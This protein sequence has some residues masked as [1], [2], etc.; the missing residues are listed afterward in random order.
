M[1]VSGFDVKKSFNREDKKIVTAILAGSTA[2]PFFVGW[3]ITS[4]YDCSK[5][6]GKADNKLAFQIVFAIAVAVT[7]IP[8]I[9]KIFLDLDLTKSRF[10][11]IVLGTAIIHD[12]VLY[13][14]LSIATGMVGAKNQSPFSLCVTV[15]MT[16]IFFAGALA[17]L[18]KFLQKV[19]NLRANL[20]FKSSATGYSLFICFLFAAV[21][22]LFNI[23]IVFGAFIAG[24]I[25][26]IMPERRFADS[27]SIIKEFSLA[28]FVP[29]YFAILGLKLDLIHKF[30]PRSF[31]WFLIFSSAVQFT[32]TILGAKAVKMSWLS[33]VNFAMVM[34]ARGGP[35]IVLASIAFDLGIISESF[36]TT[37]VLAAIL[38]SLLAGSWLRLVL[39]KGWEL[40]SDSDISICQEEAFELRRF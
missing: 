17:V 22:S 30:D 2:I 8:V 28:C 26:G 32:G 1:F 3:S 21:A 23:N 29:C 5:L 27:R 37:L 4:L 10:A 20:L 14:A 38:T 40:L 12:A 33:S 34:N 35:G 13:V 7:S 31:I 6:I 18:P 24:I 11:K 9:T 25:V 39:S 16:F 36:F 15:A 19:N